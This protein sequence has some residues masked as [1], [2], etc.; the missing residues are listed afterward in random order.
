MAHKTADTQRNLL[1]FLDQNF[2]SPESASFLPYF[3]PAALVDRYVGLKPRV[4]GSREAAY[5]GQGSYGLVVGALDLQREAP[6]ALKLQLVGYSSAR[7]RLKLYRE[8][9]LF[10]H[11]SR[12]EFSHPGVLPLLDFRMWCPPT[13]A[14]P[15]GAYPLESG[16]F[17]ALY[18]VFPFMKHGELDAGKIPRPRVRPFAFQL[19]LGLLFLHSAG[20]VH[21]D[22]KPSNILVEGER[23]AIADFG[24]A[25]VAHAEGKPPP[26]GA[27]HTPP[28][29][30]RTPTNEPKSGGAAA[31]GG[32]GGGGGGAGAFPISRNV[33][34]GGYRAPELHL[35]VRARLRA[36]PQGARAP[37]QAALSAPGALPA[38]HTLSP[39]HPARRTG[40]MPAASASG[41]RH[42]WSRATTPQRPWTCGPRA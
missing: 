23:C 14:S 37:S 40:S 25:R 34:T 5:L 42:S 31:A 18:F 21:R 33:V 30:R 24:L 6:V 3:S 39:L 20:V 11:L 9:A 8:L 19:L 27:M 1:L 7:R 12:P 13:R 36:A 16:S 26:P 10:S 28:S 29:G 15:A 22:L 4:S 32:G 17:N 38:T 41:T 2:S 35:L